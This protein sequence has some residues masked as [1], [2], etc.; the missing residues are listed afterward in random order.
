MKCL[1]AEDDMTNRLL[2]K[3]F[4]SR[5]GE[6]VVVADGKEAVLAVKAAR[7]A[8]RNYD[9]VCMDLH[10]PVMDGQAAIREIRKQ[11]AEAGVMRS[12][13]IIVTTSLS[14]MNNITNAL[15]G[16]CNGY[17][18]KPIDLGLLLNELREFG[19]VK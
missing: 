9:L 1:I 10:M 2:L 5:Y 6:C 17:M 14:D 13:K 18:V 7:Q 3:T 8:R 4:L 15:L 19:F 12:V 16:K 11:E